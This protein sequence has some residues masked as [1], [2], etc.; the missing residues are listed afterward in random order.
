M[1]IYRGIESIGSL[2]ET[3]IAVGSFDG[4]HN[5]HLSLLGTLRSRAKIMGRKSVVVSFSPH[6]RVTLSRAEGLKL[7]TSDEEKAELL[8]SVGI[9][10]LLILEFN[11]ELSSLSYEDFL[12]NYL[13]KKA[14]MAEIIVGFNNHI[15]HNSGGYENLLQLAQENNFEITRAEELISSGNKISSTVIRKLLDEGEIEQANQLLS[16][17]YLMIGRANDLQEVKFDEPLKLIPPPGVYLCEVNGSQ[18]EIK[19]DDLQRIWCFEKN[20]KVKINILRKI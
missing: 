18:Q 10:A 17:P 16:Q 14:G 9:D 6:P 19:I 8:H 2:G 15:G 12:L 1:R 4:V 11:R 3:T 5:G 7:L 13:Q 20:K